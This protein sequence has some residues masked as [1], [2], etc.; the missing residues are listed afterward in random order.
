VSDRAARVLRL[1]SPRDVRVELRTALGAVVRRHVD[2]ATCARWVRGVYGAKDAWTADFSGAQFALGRAFYA[3]LE[4]D[5]TRAYFADAPASDAR[6]EAH[7]PGLQRTLLEL[8]ARLTGARVV[9]RPGFC[10]PGVHV[11]P[12]GNEVA[13][14]GGVVHFDTEGLAR[15]HVVARRPA[16]SFVVML[17]PPERGGGLRL[18][19]ARYTGRD[20]AT[21]TELTSPGATIRY[22][23]G[24]AVVFDSYRLHQIRPFSG[25]IDRLSATVH[26]AEIDPGVWETWF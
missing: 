20:A 4:E 1:A 16:L 14:R 13:R 18:W 26:A 3:H 25:Q 15:H 22:E 21:P 17:Q 6:V 9:P 8:V 24:D 5:R 2:A 7:A 12:S 10:G 11:F 19:D 23:I